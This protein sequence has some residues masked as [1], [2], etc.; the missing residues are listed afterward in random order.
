[1]KLEEEKRKSREGE[2]PRRPSAPVQFERSS[3]MMKFNM[4]SRL[5]RAI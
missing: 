1:M 3:T 2:T 5:R 4:S